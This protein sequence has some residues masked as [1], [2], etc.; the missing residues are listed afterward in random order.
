MQTS[1]IATLFTLAVAATA[2]FAGPCTNAACGSSRQVCGRGLVCVG[3]PTLDA[4]TRTD[5]TCSGKYQ[6]CTTC[7]ISMLIQ[8]CKQRSKFETGGVETSKT[9]NSTQNRDSKLMTQPTRPWVCGLAEPDLSHSALFAHEE[10]D[11]IS[12]AE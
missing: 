9:I 5:C 10:S 1:I 4:A 7:H 2:Q 12:K 3:F 11:G 8:A 6:L